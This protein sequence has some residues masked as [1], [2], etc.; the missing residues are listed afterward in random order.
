MCDGVLFSGWWVGGKE[1]RMETVCVCVGV[2]YSRGSQV[3]PGLLVYSS[4]E[5][6]GLGAF[7]PA[8]VMKPQSP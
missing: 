8:I 6:Q 5:E 3:H 4:E 1:V 7:C 2:V